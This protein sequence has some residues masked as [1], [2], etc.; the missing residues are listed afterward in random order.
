MGEFFIIIF[1]GLYGVLI[2]QGIYYYVKTYN[3]INLKSIKKS[4]NEA[5]NGK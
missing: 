2:V 3:P 4:K 1:F 5:K